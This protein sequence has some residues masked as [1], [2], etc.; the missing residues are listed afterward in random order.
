[1]LIANVLEEDWTL[2]LT[3]TYRMLR[4]L[5]LTFRPIK[6]NS[7]GLISTGKEDW[8]GVLESPYCRTS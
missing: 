2:S 1:M 6:A 4:N 8:N 5:R 7:L 3:V